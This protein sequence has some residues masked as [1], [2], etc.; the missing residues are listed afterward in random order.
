MVRDYENAGVGAFLFKAARRAA[1]ELGLIFD[2]E[3][4]N[5]DSVTELEPARRKAQIKAAEHNIFLQFHMDK[6]MHGV[7]YKNIEDL[8]LSKWLTFTFVRSAGLKSETEG[9]IMARQDGVF[10]ILV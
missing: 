8:G 4:V 1:Y 9:F 10:D 6:P 2:A 7:F 5:R 3:R